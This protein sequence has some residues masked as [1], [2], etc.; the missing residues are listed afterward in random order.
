MPRGSPAQ[1]EAGV[2]NVGDIEKSHRALVALSR[3]VA[4]SGQKRRLANLS[5][6]C[7]LRGRRMCGD[8]QLQHG[9]TLTLTQA[10]DQHHLPIREFQRIVMGHG[11]VEVD[12]PEAREPLPDPLVWQNAE[13]K[14]R[15][16]F[17]ILVERN[18]GA[19]QQAYRN[20]RLARGG[21]AASD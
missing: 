3:Y 13:T 11:V 20:M 5:P 1:C 9:R 14:R 4:G 8:R 21:E 12:L 15:L 16:A 18:F 6:H 2:R 17:D 10:R 7:L 19:G